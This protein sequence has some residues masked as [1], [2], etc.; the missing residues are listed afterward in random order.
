VRAELLGAL[1][2][3][4]IQSRADMDKNHLDS[5]HLITLTPPPVV[6]PDE[7]IGAHSSWIHNQMAANF[8]LL[9][10]K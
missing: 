1:N 2:K 7:L 6:D 4:V 8:V 10:S 5:K 9:L 3:D